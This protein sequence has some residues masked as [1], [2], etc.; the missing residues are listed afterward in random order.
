ML[1]S[2]TILTFLFMLFSI[3]RVM[4]QQPDTTRYTGGEEIEQHIENLAE[5]SDVEMDYSDWVEELNLLR[6]RPV[7]LNS[8]D[9]NELRRLFFLNE[10][11]ISNLLE[12][13]NQYGQLASIYELQVIDGFNEKV[14]SQILPFI[15][16][17]AY[18]PEKF[19]IKRALKYCGTDVMFRYQRVLQE[20]AGY[21]MYPIR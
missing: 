11:Q 19:S 6:I 16:L 8:G 14:V 10:L 18:I 15:T 7:N 3:D 1:K 4:A 12:Y 17:S 2:L 13:I 5:R 9:E 21:A 20:Q